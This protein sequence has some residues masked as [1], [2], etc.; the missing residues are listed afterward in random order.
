MNSRF[1]V[2]GT[3]EH[4]ENNWG[5]EEIK[6]NHN[7]AALSSETVNHNE[8]IVPKQLILDNILLYCW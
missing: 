5:Q 6:A 7:K 2:I 4:V 1:K 8:K 3:V